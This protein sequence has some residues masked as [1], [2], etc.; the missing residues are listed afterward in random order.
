MTGCLPFVQA[1][2][3]R[4]RVAR[5]NAIAGI[6]NVLCVR[7]RKRWRVT[8]VETGVYVG[9]GNKEPDKMTIERTFN[10][11]ILLWEKELELA[12][13]AHQELFSGKKALKACPKPCL[14]VAQDKNGGCRCLLL[15]A[16]LCF[17]VRQFPAF[18]RENQDNIPHHLAWRIYHL[19]DQ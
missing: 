4:W 18:Q 13:S 7:R 8:K 16:V 9:R 14:P 12:S 15:G 5:V 6:S 17:G 19:H 11:S 2:V 1:D 3:Y 10:L